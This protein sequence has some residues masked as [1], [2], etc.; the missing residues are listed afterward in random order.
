MSD[1]EPGRAC[2]LSGFYV[3]A[4]VHLTII[5][6]Q[7]PTYQMMKVSLGA[8]GM[9]EC[10][11]NSKYVVFSQAIQMDGKYCVS[12][13]VGP[14][15]NITLLVLVAAS[16][17]R[18]SPIITS[19]LLSNLLTSSQGPLTPSSSAL[20]LHVVGK[21]GDKCFSLGTVAPLY[22]RIPDHVPFPG[23]AKH[24]SIPPPPPPAYPTRPS[25]LLTS[26]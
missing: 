11:I 3:S 22:L 5:E 26:V 10:L 1:I 17:A 2:C 15:I 19:T 13:Q 16:S 14:S 18:L 6:F 4:C 20:L 21:L 7:N 24:L 25:V 12:W 9:T 8:A 23:N